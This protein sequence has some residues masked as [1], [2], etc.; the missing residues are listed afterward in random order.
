MCHN[1]SNQWLQALRCY[2]ELDH[3]KPLQT[4]SKAASKQAGTHACMMHGTLF[5]CLCLPVVHAGP[6]NPIILTKK[7]TRLENARTHSF[8]K[9]E[10]NSRTL[11]QWKKLPIL[12]LSAWSNQHHSCTCTHDGH[13]TWLVM[14]CGYL[15]LYIYI[16]DECNDGN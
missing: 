2:L 1:G 14:F 12:Y 4:T 16:R 10:R 7:N 11:F 8:Q 3:V 9:K 13:C 15:P 6:S 5:T